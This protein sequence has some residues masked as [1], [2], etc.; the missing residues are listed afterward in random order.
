[1]VMFPFENERLGYFGSVMLYQV[2]A[3]TLFSISVY[4]G[5]L[6]ASCY[7]LFSIH[8]IRNT[9]QHWKNAGAFFE[10][11][12]TTLPEHKK[13]RI[14]LLSIPL[15]Y[16]DIYAFRSTERITYAYQ[17]VH[18][19]EYTDRLIPVAWTTFYSPS[20]SI[21]VEQ[22]DSNTLNVSIKTKGTS[23]WMQ[24]GGLGSTPIENEDFI[25][26]VDQW[27][28]GYTLNIKHLKQEDCF[29]YISNNQFK[30]FK[31]R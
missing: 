11:C 19:K 8:E 20:D 21:L 1:M 29:Y 16:Q 9:T 6:V 31:L 26:H 3:L 30:A 17:L 23:W 10:R 4:F 18:K 7:L 25:F 15:K 12:I 2:F 27:G 24:E 28:L 14:F 13:G 22:T 5:Y